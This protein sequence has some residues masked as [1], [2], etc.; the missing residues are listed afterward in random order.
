MTKLEAESL[1]SRRRNENKFNA[2][3]KEL[4]ETKAKETIKAQKEVYL[5]YRKTMEQ[6]AKGIKV[7]IFAEW[8]RDLDANKAKAKKDWEDTVAYIFNTKN[9][10]TISRPTD[11]TIKAKAISQEILDAANATVDDSPVT[12]WDKLLELPAD[13]L[14]QTV[15]Q[16]QDLGNVLFDLGSAQR[17]RELSEVQ[18]NYAARMQ[19]AEGNADLQA[20]LQKELEQEQ[21][22]INRE[23]AIAEKNNAIFNVA[24]NTA[25]AVS[26]VWGQTGIFGIAAEIPVIAM[27]A[28][29][30]AAILSRPL[31]GFFKGT[32]NAPAGL[33]WVAEHGAEL[34]TTKS[35]E[36]Y[37]AKEKQVV[38][39]SGGERVDT[40]ADT[41]RL[42]NSAIYNDIV[43]NGNNG[44]E[45]RM[46]RMISKLENLNQLNVNFDEKGMTIYAQQGKSITKY[47]NSKGRK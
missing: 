11:I 24:M 18:E 2:L 13:K 16:I 19:A 22:R 4:N 44:M 47:L 41:Q 21:K 7:P 45:T 38:N 29:Q 17:E 20:K 26:K 37:L 10:T 30:T 8:K 33:A 3:S 32:E 36:Q 43:I 1:K 28:L 40:A 5:A 31:P 9:G 39:F 6:N 14:Q 23:S 42:L 12:F 25:V 46:D 15:G 27:G 34:I 35:G